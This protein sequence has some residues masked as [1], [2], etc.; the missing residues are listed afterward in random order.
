MEISPLDEFADFL[1]G[2]GFLLDGKI[3]LDKYVYSNSQFHSKKKSWY[4]ASY[5]LEHNIV[6]AVWGDWL[7]QPEAQKFCSTKIDKIDPAQRDQIRKLLAAEKKRRDKEAAEKFE[8]SAKTAQEYI[9][10]LPVATVHPYIEKKKIKPFGALIDERAGKLVIPWQ[11]TKGDVVSYQTIGPDGFKKNAEDCKKRG[12]F[13]MLGRRYTS[14]TYICEGWATACSIKEATGKTVIMA[15]DAYNILPVA[16][17]IR[18]I[19]G[20]PL[21]LA[22]DN[23]HKKEKNTGLECGQKVAKDVPG[24]SIVWPEKIEGTDFNDL[25]GELGIEDLRA[26]LGVSEWSSRI[27]IEKTTKH[28]TLQPLDF[29]VEDFL[30]RDTTSLLYGEPSAKKSFIVQDIGMSVAA[31][32]DWHGRAVTPGAV[33]YVAGEGHQDLNHRID[34][35]KKQRGLHRNQEPPFFNTQHGIDLLDESWTEELIDLALDLPGSEPGIPPV[36][37]IIVD[38]LSA[39]FGGGDE[40]GAEMA[41]FINNLNRVALETK[42]HVLIVHHSGKDGNKGARGGSAAK[43]NVYTFMKVAK[44]NDKQSRLM[45]EK[46]K[47][48][49]ELKPITFEFDIVPLGIVE[50]MRGLEKEISALVPKVAKDG[51]ALDAMQSSLLDQGVKMGKN[52]KVALEILR[53]ERDRRIQNKPDLKEII[54]TRDEVLRLLSDDIPVDTRRHNTIKSLVDKDYLNQRNSQTLVFRVDA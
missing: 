19:T 11:N 20:A 22:V 26:A 44:V 47:G 43:G 35:W 18:K 42:S 14:P 45:M 32:M 34:G 39:N 30:V 7:V 9:S 25:H 27:K 48:L 31:G 12:S 33:L 6:Y 10:V 37:L 17:S 40:N 8:A 5:N 52:Q 41:Q 15:I 46:Q 24:C 50:D 36:N 4:K 51:N 2:Q 1:A 3:Q 28:K 23:D 49:E 53:S 16:Q 21:V 13:A 29:V 38:T 54:F